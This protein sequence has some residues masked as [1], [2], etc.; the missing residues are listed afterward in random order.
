MGA[1]DFLH[2]RYNP[3]HIVRH[4]TP[5]MQTPP[6]LKRHPNFGMAAY[7]YDKQ[8]R[9]IIRLDDTNQAIPDYAVDFFYKHPRCNYL[10]D[11]YGN[12]TESTL[13]D[14]A[15]KKR[16]SSFQ[17]PITRTFNRLAKEYF[18]KPD[19]RHQINKEAKTRIN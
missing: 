5:L 19:Y 13:L 11:D 17:M 15:K 16:V 8:G 12:P 2:K 10:V 14:D 9:R 4:S 6:P 7:F 3:M 1:I 18:T